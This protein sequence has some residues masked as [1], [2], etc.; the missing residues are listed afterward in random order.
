MVEIISRTVSEKCRGCKTSF[1]CPVDRALSELRPAEIS[2]ARNIV[3]SNGLVLGE[4]RDGAILI[5]H[6]FRGSVNNGVGVY[7]PC[8]TITITHNKHPQGK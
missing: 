3:E 8:G 5:A 4:G 6:C 7:E 2:G 1:R